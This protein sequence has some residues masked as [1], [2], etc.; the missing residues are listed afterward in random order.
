MRA[1][2]GLSCSQIGRAGAA[3]KAACMGA[4][5]LSGLVL[6]GFLLAFL[7]AGLRLA[8]GGFAA[9]GTLE[10]A[11]AGVGSGAA[12]ALGVE[13]LRGLAALASEAS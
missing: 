8:L 4:G 11:G 9:T 10:A 1:L 7:S 2:M 12:G 13:A 6:R 3:G 5:V